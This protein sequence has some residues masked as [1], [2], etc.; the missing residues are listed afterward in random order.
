MHLVDQRLPTAAR[1]Q[2]TGAFTAMH[3]RKPPYTA[4]RLIVPAKL[5]TRA[6]RLGKPSAPANTA[7]AWSR[8]GPDSSSAVSGRTLNDTLCGL[9]YFSDN[10][11]RNWLLFRQGGEAFEGE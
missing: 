6:W 7:R 11:F 9:T 8:S 4:W 10:W 3:D 5:V 1:V 2:V